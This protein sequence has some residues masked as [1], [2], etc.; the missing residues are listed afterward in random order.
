MRKTISL[1]VFALLCATQQKMYAQVGYFANWFD[2]VDKT[3]NEQ[4]NWVNPIATTTPRIGEAYRYDQLW[5]TNAKGVTTNNYDGGKGIETIPFAKVEVALNLPPYIDHNNPKVRNGWGDIAFRVKYRL[6]SANEEHGNYILTT[7]LVWSLPTGQ[8]SNGA[9][10]AV[11]TP[12]IAYGKGFGNFDVVGTFGVA[13]P[14][15]DTNRVGRNYLL[16]NTFQY[17]LWRKIWPEIELN[18]TIFQQGKNDGMKQKSLLW[19]W[20]WDDFTS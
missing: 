10:H 2:R 3:R 17:R 16:N 4:P 1:F 5:Q 18:S 14:V 8:Y 20:S 9:L 12:T 15:A 19:G 13:L 6:L 7:F 11:I